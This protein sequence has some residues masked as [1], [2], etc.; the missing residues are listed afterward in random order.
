[1]R[2]TIR[3]WLIYNVLQISIVRRIMLLKT[4]LLLIRHDKKLKFIEE[5]LILG[6]ICVGLIAIISNKILIYHD[7]QYA[8]KSLDEFLIGNVKKLVVSKEGTL[9]TISAMFIGIYLTILTLLGSVKADSTFAV[10]TEE[11]FRR[12]IK[13][14]K[15]AFIGS[16][17][18]L[19]YSLFYS[20]IPNEWLGLMI[21]ITLLTYMIL[22]AGRF[23]LVIYW[24]FSL[25]LKEL[26]EKI[27]RDKKEKRHVSNLHKKLEA[28]LV[29]QDRKREDS[30]SLDFNRKMK[31]REMK[32]KNKHKGD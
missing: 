28:F 7:C 3:K 14:I 19:A 20:L 5:K 13:Y 30:I 21:N 17:L 25:D 1:M 23:G 15:N 12:I 31:E 6:I 10:L 29:E 18:Y 32:L 27:E 22:S 26:H 24:I 9:T 8:I 2:K 4:K 16:L 11:N